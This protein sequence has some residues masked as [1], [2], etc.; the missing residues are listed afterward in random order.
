M[1]SCSMDGSYNRINPSKDL[2]SINELH[3]SEV[4]SSTFAYERVGTNN[5]NDNKKPSI[6]R[7][8]SFSWSRRPSKEHFDE[9]GDNSKGTPTPEPPKKTTTKKSSGMKSFFNGILDSYKRIMQSAE[10]VDMQLSDL[11]PGNPMVAPVTPA[12]STRSIKYISPSPGVGRNSLARVAE[13]SS[14]ER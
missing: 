7:R 10:E 12:A 5:N 13:E 2:Y 4:P 3:A 9:L 8:S 6:S 14:R 1:R 11:Y